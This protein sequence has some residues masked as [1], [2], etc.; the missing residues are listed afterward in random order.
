[1]A[2]TTPGSGWETP[3]EATD[4]Y[5]WDKATAQLA[6]QAPW[7]PPGSAS[8]YHAQNLG[9]L[10][11]ELVRRVAGK[12]LKE[13]VADEIAGPLD[14]DFQIGALPD[15]HGRIAEVIP[16]PSFDL[17]LDLLPEDNPMRKTFLG[18]APDA[19]AANTAA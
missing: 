10:I 1:M 16:P 19:E 13:F 5:D 4:M 18:P 12:S 11:G 7:W 6:A 14:A 8:G 2:T 15:D 9:H 17:P 3:F